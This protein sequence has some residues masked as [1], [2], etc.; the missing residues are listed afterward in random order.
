MG[1]VAVM[2]RCNHR[3]GRS[4]SKLL[5]F[6]RLSDNGRSNKKANEI[7]VEQAGIAP[8]QFRASTLF[9]GVEPFGAVFL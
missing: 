5:R 2:I 3:E 8:E 4:K 9:G 6:G 1:V 7:R